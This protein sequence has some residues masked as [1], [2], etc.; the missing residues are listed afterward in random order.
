[1]ARRFRTV[2]VLALLLTALSVP[3]QAA[4]L[5]GK[6]T[7][8]STSSSSSLLEDL[9]GGL[10]AFFGWIQSLVDAEHGTIVP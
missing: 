6:G 9:N 2:A 4:R 5:S 1:M 3:A 10:R 8:G 7:A